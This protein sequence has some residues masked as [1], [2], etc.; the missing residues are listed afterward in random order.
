[1]RLMFGFASLKSVGHHAYTHAKISL[2]LATELNTLYN[3]GNTPTH[4][5][6]YW[7][8]K[9]YGYMQVYSY[10]LLRSEG[11]SIQDE[12]T[13]LPNH[14]ITITYSYSYSTVFSLTYIILAWTPLIFK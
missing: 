1:V 12:C 8:A 6:C 14:A 3:L 11:A 10:R 9:V 13:Q 2:K 4:T 5:H 7:I